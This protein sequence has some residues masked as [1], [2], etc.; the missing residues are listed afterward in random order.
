[1]KASNSSL[2][3]PGSWRALVRGHDLDLPDDLLDLLPMGVCVCSRDG[4]IIRYNRAAAE[5]WGHAPE[6]GHL[7]ERFCGSYRLYG[8]DGSLI[9]KGE[10]PVADVL[11]TGIP[12]RNREIMIERPDGSHIRVLADIDPLIDESGAI[13]GAVE[14]FRAPGSSARPQKA[15]N[16]AEPQSHELLQVL[17]A[18]IYTTDA[19]GRLTFYNKAAAGLWGYYPQLGKIEFCGSWKL[20]S[21]DG[22]PMPH[23]EC[24]MALA[25]KEKRPHHGE[26]AVA[27]R[28]DGS[29]IPF[30]AYPTPLFDAS[31]NLTG[32]VNML[33]DIT[34]RK[35][36][37]DRIRNSEA[38]YRRIFD[39]ARVSLWEQDFSE[40]ADF[41]DSIRAEGVTDPCAYF[42][43]R[44]DRLREAVRR[45]R[46]EDVNAFTLKLFEA[47]RKELLLGSLADVFVPETMPVFLELLSTLWKGGHCFESGIVMQ[48]LRGR[49]LELTF[50][51]AF[52]GAKGEQTLVSL[53]DISALKTAERLLQ[54]QIE[55]GRRRELAA[56]RLA[57]IVESSEDAILAKDLNGII[58]SWNK[59]AERLFGYAEEEVTGKLITI[60]IPPE[61][62]DEEPAILARIRRGERVDPYET[63]RRR[64]DGSLVD[65]SLT[66]SPIK[67]AHGQIVGASKIARDITERRRAEEQQNLLLREM[68]HRVKN[69]F[70]VAGSIV[71]LSARTASTPEDLACSVQERLAALAR[72]HELTLTRPSHGMPFRLQATTLH[73]LFGKILLPFESREGAERVSVSGPDIPVGAASV[74]AFALLLHEF[75]TNAAKYGALA[76]AAGRI[77]IECSE[78]D[79]RFTIIWKEHGGPPV[80]QEFEDEGFGGLLVRATVRHQ[81]GGE[82]AREWRPEGLTIR[83]SFESSRVAG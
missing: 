25:L 15:F 52:E 81:L 80:T 48:T 14:C 1:M 26:E 5:L 17:P 12:V 41:L 46:T 61:R 34:E 57:A 62:L 4:E 6:Y 67:N 36:A 33:V 23:D 78:D 3:V 45:V 59:G 77:D 21:A 24:P 38:R 42:A 30:M 76:A 18:A 68:S 44:P 8:L 65:I 71:A 64:K 35:S 22:A 27:E 50:T 70:T 13:A 29:R 53:V 60:L 28:P 69:L 37:E 49:R 20:F 82:I 56:Q 55:E 79:G 72:A 2:R 19:S 7:A 51:V 58:T 39:N 66:V 73:A 54:Q 31:G 83:L 40:A 75:A 11:A 32:A 10:C 9:P 43:S 63:V 74:T 16:G 47:D